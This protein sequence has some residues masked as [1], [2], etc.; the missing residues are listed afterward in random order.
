V[1]LFFTEALCEFG[2][3]PERRKNARTPGRE[4]FLDGYCTLSASGPF[5]IRFTLASRRG[6]RGPTFLGFNRGWF[7][8]LGG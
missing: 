2:R 8:G 4:A 3:H 6:R 5:Q 7:L 1:F